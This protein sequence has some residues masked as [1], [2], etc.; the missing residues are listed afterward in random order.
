MI[1]SK[2][3]GRNRT[4]R[5]VTTYRENFRCDPEGSLALKFLRQ[6]RLFGPIQHFLLSAQVGWPMA[7]CARGQSASFV[8]GWSRIILDAGGLR[9]RL[10]IKRRTLAGERRNQKGGCSLPVLAYETCGQITFTQ[11]FLPRRLT[12]AAC[13]KTACRPTA[14]RGHTVRSA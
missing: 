11:R 2:Q 4:A 3:P 1:L 10:P 6:A 5:V 9:S 13:A 7:H 12:D 8:K 14:A